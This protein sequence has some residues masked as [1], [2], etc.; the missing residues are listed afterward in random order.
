MELNK[1][2]RFCR[3]QRR[4][5][6]HLNQDFRSH[7]IHV[8]Q[9]YGKHFHWK[10]NI[11]K[12]QLEH[13]G[14]LAVRKLQSWHRERKL[15]P[16]SWVLSGDE[17]I[18]FKTHRNLPSSSLVHAQGRIILV[19]SQI[20]A[21]RAWKNS[22]REWQ[23]WDEKYWEAICFQDPCWGGTGG[24]ERNH[25]LGKAWRVLQ[26]YPRKLHREQQGEKHQS[27]GFNFLKV[28]W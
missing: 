14:V 27:L 23:V 11:W 1:E 16:F 8:S 5:N 15:S 9:S 2:V 18:S 20:K 17:I 25:P 21:I 10:K 26:G 19:H 7:F 22:A 6:W 24:R 28:Q 13:P 4:C 12:L 3:L